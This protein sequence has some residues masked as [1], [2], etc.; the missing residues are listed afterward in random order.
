MA[1]ALIFIE[2]AKEVDAIKDYVL[3]DIIIIAL[4]PSAGVE[5]SRRGIPFENTISLFGFD[6]HSE[7]LKKS[8]LIVEGIR[9]LLTL[10]SDNN[11]QH[12][13]EK[14]WIIYFRVHLNQYVYHLILYL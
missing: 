10:L 14:T 4:L 3:D 13:F 6:G 11:V 7:T 8:K 2:Y 12:A 9:P 5:L 1:K